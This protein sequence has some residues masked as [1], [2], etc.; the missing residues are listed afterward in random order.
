MVRLP[1]RRAG[2][3]L[4]YA[5]ETSTGTAMRARRLIDGTSFGPEALNVIGKT[6]AAAWAEIQLREQ[7]GRGRAPQA[8]KRNAR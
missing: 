7:S 5:E 3:P 2:K 4:A 8:G 6:F 1:H